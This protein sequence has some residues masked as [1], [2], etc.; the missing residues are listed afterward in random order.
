MEIKRK[1]LKE[2]E[3]WIYDGGGREGKLT[4][5]Q[6]RGIGKRESGKLQAEIWCGKR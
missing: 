1:G 6:G 4:I 3:E 5:E 2:N